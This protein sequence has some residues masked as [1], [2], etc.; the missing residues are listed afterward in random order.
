MTANTP[1]HCDER[2]VDVNQSQNIRIFTKAYQL[3]KIFHFNVLR[4]FD[5]VFVVVVLS[6]IESRFCGIRRI[7]N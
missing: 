5:L 1:F 7:D 2:K 4:A 6:S 3:S